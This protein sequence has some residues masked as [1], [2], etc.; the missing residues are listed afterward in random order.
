MDKTDILKRL[1]DAYPDA[2]IDTAGADCNFEIQ[3]ISN[4]FKGKSLLARQRE[5]L[6]LFKAELG[7]GTLHALSV[8]AKTPSE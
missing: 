5:V 7:S 6:A 1:A 3:I 2:T 4:D 8:K